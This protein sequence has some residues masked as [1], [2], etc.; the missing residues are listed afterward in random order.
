[1]FGFEIVTNGLSDPVFGATP[2]IGRL[3]VWAGDA[4][5]RPRFSLLWRDRLTAPAE[6][7]VQDGN[8][9][10]GRFDLVQSVQAGVKS[11]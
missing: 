8:A 6:P 9:A 10:S 5:S 3:V 7:V 4:G 1:M 2:P 11:T